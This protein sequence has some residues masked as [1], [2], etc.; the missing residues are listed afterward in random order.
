MN[1]ARFVNLRNLQNVLRSFKIAMRIL[2]ISDLNLTLTLN[3]T[4]T[5]TLTLIL[6]VYKSLS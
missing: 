3:P 4:L 5:Q 2:Q 1:V 6:A